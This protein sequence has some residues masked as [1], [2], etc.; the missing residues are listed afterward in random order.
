MGS[1][2][3]HAVADGA[4]AE[5]PTLSEVFVAEFGKQPVE[6]EVLKNSQSAAARLIESHFEEVA[7]LEARRDGIP[8]WLKFSA[9]PRAVSYNDLK[10]MERLADDRLGLKHHYS[11]DFIDSLEKRHVGW[12]KVYG[13]GG[14]A[15]AGGILRYGIPLLRPVGGM[16]VTLG[17]AAIGAIA[18]YKV[19]A[20]IGQHT[21]DSFNRN[22]NYLSLEK[23]NYGNELGAGWSRN[24]KSLGGVGIVGGLVA[25]GFGAYRTAIGLGVAGIVSY[26]GASLAYQMGRRSAA[27][28]LDREADLGRRMA[29]E[30]ADRAGQ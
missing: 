7:N 17:V 26:L 9:K 6:R 15:L 16:G 14:G 28:E 5:L 20:Y 13:I 24:A 11:P 12:S 21:F 30:W 3:L 25:A 8:S 4:R 2:E 23:E 10:E 29:K 27:A 19:G 22:S 18:G 1:T